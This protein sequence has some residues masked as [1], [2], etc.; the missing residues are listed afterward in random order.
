MNIWCKTWS[1]K[2][3]SFMWALWNKVIVVNTWRVKV[4]N[5]I[6][7]TFLLCSNEEE[8]TFNKFWE[9][10]HAQ[11]AWEYTQGIVCELAYG[12]KPSQV[13]A[14]L[15]WN[16]FVFAAKSPRQVQHVENIWS[17]LRGITLWI[18]WSEWND[19]VFNNKRW[20]VVKIRKVIWDA[21]LDYGRVVWNRC[22]KLIRKNF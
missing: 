5:S 8:S 13:V 15:H 14:P 11:Q 9:C 21:L 16:Q 18:L 2:E 19:L 12:N 7:Q 20:N 22:M 1:R 3:T 17:L 6:N 4:G 10:C